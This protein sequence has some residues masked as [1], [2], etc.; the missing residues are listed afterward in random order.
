MAVK[1]IRLEQ[2]D[3][4]WC[5]D[6]DEYLKSKLKKAKENITYLRESSRYHVDI[7]NALCAGSDTYS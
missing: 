3:G 4:V 6:C 5:H 2:I 1:R 7:K